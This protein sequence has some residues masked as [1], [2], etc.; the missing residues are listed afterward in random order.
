MP[1]DQDLLLNE[2]YTL[3]KKLSGFASAESW[4]ATDREGGRVLVKLW[5]YEGE[6]PNEVIRALW[7]RELRNLF[8]LS[9]SPDADSKLVVLHDAG[10][11]KSS[12]RFVMVLSAPGFEPLSAILESRNRYDWLRD[13]RQAELRVALWRALRELA[14]GLGQL[15]QQQMLLDERQRAPRFGCRS[16]KHA[17][18]RLRMD[19]PSWTDIAR[20]SSNNSRYDFRRI[21]RYK[22][23]PHFRIRLV[24]LRTRSRSSACWN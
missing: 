1:G 3:T 8:R 7:D 4:L 13:M 5:P 21:E 10:V 16:R 11:D 24:S 22:A 17:P 12:R 6:R 15:H 14:Q 18:R 20:C 23:H 9:S 19:S 2:R